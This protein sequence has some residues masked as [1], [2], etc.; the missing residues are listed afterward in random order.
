M[1]IIELDKIK[2]PMKRH[3]FTQYS[4]QTLLDVDRGGR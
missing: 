4:I 3:F 1:E 2:V